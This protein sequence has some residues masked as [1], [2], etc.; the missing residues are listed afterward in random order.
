MNVS[1]LQGGIDCQLAYHSDTHHWFLL[2][3]AEQLNGLLHLVGPPFQQSVK[4]L[5][6]RSKY[7]GRGLEDVGDVFVHL[8]G[9]AHEVEQYRG[10]RCNICTSM[11][12]PQE[13]DANSTLDEWLMMLFRSARGYQKSLEQR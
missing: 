9:H 5:L 1:R 12:S 6:Q 11:G 10:Q 2:E 8:F 3:E 4:L 13:H 7:F